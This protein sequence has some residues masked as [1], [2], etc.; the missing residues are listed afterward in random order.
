MKASEVN[1][2][3]AHTELFENKLFDI[4]HDILMALC[5]YPGHYTGQGW[6]YKALKSLMRPP[7]AYLD[8]V[9]SPGK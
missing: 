6:P 3:D 5:K 9:R 8:P 7:R 2:V 4:M 1:F